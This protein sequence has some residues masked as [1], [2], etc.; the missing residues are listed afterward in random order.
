MDDEI[1]GDWIT[2][3]MP[4]L[5]SPFANHFAFLNF[6]ALPLFVAYERRM[7]EPADAFERSRSASMFAAVV[8]L[9]AVPEYV[10]HDLGAWPSEGELRREL[11][12][13]APALGELHELANALKHCRRG[14][15]NRATGRF[16]VADGK[17][18]AADVAPTDA[19]VG[20]EMGEGG[21]V[22]VTLSLGAPILAR[23]PEC[24]EEC[25]RFWVAA[26]QSPDGCERLILE[27]CGRTFA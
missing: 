10:F 21:A 6:V 27:T 22:R 14:R 17:L 25:W 1:S 20:V 26:S 3:P 8:A 12:R 5:G 11:A 4:L 19:Q 16:E 18:H 24:L 9:D 13:G 23:I 2:Q 7:R 15:L